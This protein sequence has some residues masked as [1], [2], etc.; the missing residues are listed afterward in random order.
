MIVWIWINPV[1]GFSFMRLMHYLDSLTQLCR[2]LLVPLAFALLLVLLLKQ[3]QLYD[4]LVDIYN[5]CLPV[6]MG[7][8]IAFLF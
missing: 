5:S 3:M 6:F 7:V 4:W 1:A 2:K 8:V